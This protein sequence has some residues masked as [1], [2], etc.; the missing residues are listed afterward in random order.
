MNRRDFL[1]TLGLAAPVAVVAPTYFFAPK[2]GWPVHKVYSFKDIKGTLDY[3][4]LMLGDW[5]LP[6]MD[7]GKSLDDIGRIIGISRTPGLYKFPELTT[8]KEPE[9]DSEL[10]KRMIAAMERLTI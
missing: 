10:R 9:T 2:G 3:R 8:I 7:T 4:H 5:N 6:L 1:K